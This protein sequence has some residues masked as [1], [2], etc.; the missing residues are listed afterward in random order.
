MI[1]DNAIGVA[2]DDDDDDLLSLPILSFLVFGVI[3]SIVIL[4][5]YLLILQ[6]TSTMHIYQ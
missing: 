4:S 2:N 6:Q 1:D 5:I 3:T